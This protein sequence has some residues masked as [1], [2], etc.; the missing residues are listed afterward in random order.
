VQQDPKDGITALI[1]PISE[2]GTN[3]SHTHKLAETQKSS[4]GE[5][6]LSDTKFMTTVNTM[7]IYHKFQET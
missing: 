7:L 2:G 1:I 6:L 5:F 4:R 3:L